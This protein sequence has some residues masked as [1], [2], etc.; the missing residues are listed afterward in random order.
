EDGSQAKVRSQTE[1]VAGTCR[2]L[3]LCLGFRADSFDPSTASTG[4][5]GGH[6][7][8]RPDAIICRQS[9]ARRT[10]HPRLSHGCFGRRSHLQR[11]VAGHAQIS[12]GTGARHSDYGC[13]LWWRPDCVF[14]LPLAVAIAAADGGDGVG[15]IQQMAAS[16]TVLQTTNT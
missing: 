8:H 7:L 15:M 9:T 2:R 6:A 10:A 3:A 13:D 4:V 1:G 12:A 16:N 14:V 5:V 11:H